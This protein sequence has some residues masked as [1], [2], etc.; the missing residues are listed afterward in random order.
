M[1]VIPVKAAIQAGTGCGYSMGSVLEDIS[2]G[3]K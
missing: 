3:W 2:D 1:G